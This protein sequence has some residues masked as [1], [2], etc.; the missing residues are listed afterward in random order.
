MNTFLLNILGL[1]VASLGAMLCALGQ[2]CMGDP[3]TPA[4]IYSAFRRTGLLRFAGWGVVAVG[5]ALVVISY[6]LLRGSGWGISA[7][8]AASACW[9]ASH[10]A[11]DGRR[12]RVLRMSGGRA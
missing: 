9:A 1:A 11:M 7:L 10:L 3:R 2:R 5:G 12:F 6:A 4:Q 8:V